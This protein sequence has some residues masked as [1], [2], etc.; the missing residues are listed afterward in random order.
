MCETG[1]DGGSGKEI[2]AAAGIAQAMEAAARATAVGGL[3][4]RDAV[5]PAGMEV[6][7][8]HPKTVIGVPAVPAAPLGGETETPQGQPG[9]AGGD[10]DALRTSREAVAQPAT[11]GAAPPPQDGLR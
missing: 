3:G 11:T 10:Q 9:L 5:D 8:G 6:V 2:S 1:R 7:L 4:G